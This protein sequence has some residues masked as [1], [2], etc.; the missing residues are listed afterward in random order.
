MKTAFA[1]LLF[2]AI[3]GYAASL[4]CYSCSSTLTAKSDCRDWV[5]NL[6]TITCATAGSSCY[7]SMVKAT[8]WGVKIDR[9]C[10]DKCASDDSCMNAFGSGTCRTCCKKDRCNIDTPG[11]ADMAGVS[12]ALLLVSSFLTVLGAL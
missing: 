12:A 6:T 2:G 1:V 4:E 11:G 10:M 9:G 7:S 3:F 8:T 5:A